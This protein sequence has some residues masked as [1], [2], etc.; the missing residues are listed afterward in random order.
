MAEPEI[1]CN[2]NNKLNLEWQ[3]SSVHKKLCTSAKIYSNSTRSDR[4]FLENKYLYMQVRWLVVTEVRSASTRNAQWRVLLQHAIMVHCCLCITVLCCECYFSSSSGITC[5]LCMT[6]L[7]EVRASSSSPRLPN[8]VSFAAS[9]AE[10]AHGEKLHTHYLITL[11]H[12]AYLMPREPKRLR[13]GI[14]NSLL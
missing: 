7:F 4:I 9:I 8:V 6:R 2:S 11:T 14:N 3:P 12:P 1:F 10:L 5:F 13:F